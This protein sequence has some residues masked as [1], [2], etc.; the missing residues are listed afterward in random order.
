MTTA[1]RIAA[2]REWLEYVASGCSDDTL[3]GSVERIVTDL[4]WACDEIERLEKEWCSVIKR[5]RIRAKTSD[6]ITETA[7]YNIHG[8]RKFESW[9]DRRI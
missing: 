2:I 3:E 9:P 6:A 1:G 5:K 7:D 4:L 8:I